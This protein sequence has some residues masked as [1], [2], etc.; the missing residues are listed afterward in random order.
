MQLSSHDSRRTAQDGWNYDAEPV[1]DVRG[2]RLDGAFAR[3]QTFSF[4]GRQAT[5]I[6]REYSADLP[7]KASNSITRRARTDGSV[8]QLR[9]REEIPMSRYHVLMLHRVYSCCGHVN[10]PVRSELSSAPPSDDFTP[11]WLEFN[12]E[13]GITTVPRIHRLRP[14][15]GVF[16]RRGVGRR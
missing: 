15:A 13:P 10:G 2:H 16:S 5:R 6:L 7:A 8:N 11:P 1:S 3:V 12:S 4:G 14:G 9:H